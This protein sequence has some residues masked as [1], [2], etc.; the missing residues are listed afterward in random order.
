MGTPG[1]IHAGAGDLVLNPDGSPIDVGFTSEGATLTYNAEIEPIKVDQVLSPVGFFV[2]GEECI[3][4]TILSEA[5]AEKLK[6]ALGNAGTVET[7]AAGASQK[8]YSQIK[9]GGN[10]ILTDYVLEYTAPKRTAANLN[11]KIRLYKVNIS[12]S[13]EAVFKKDGTLGFKVTFKAA[14]D[15]TKSAGEQ[16]GYWREETADMTGT[17]PTL[18]VSTTVPADAATDIAVDTTI[19]VTFNR[20][21]HPES[22]NLGNFVLMTDAGAGVA[23]SVAQTGAAEVTFTPSANL[24]ASTTYLFVVA[25]DVRALDDYTEMADNEYIDFTTAA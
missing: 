9:F 3:F 6:I 1:K 22:L 11:I 19:V 18:A 4:E 13:F 2:P 23:G 8:G 16:L 5:S 7:Q 12:P 25:K 20:S 21:I 17:T 24:S 10:Y 15:T 14:A